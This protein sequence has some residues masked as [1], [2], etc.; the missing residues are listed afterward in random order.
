MLL[1]YTIFDNDDN[2]TANLIFYPK[3]ELLQVIDAIEL[4]FFNLYKTLLIILTNEI[5]GV[6]LCERLINKE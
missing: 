6:N 3:K 4:L 2:Q 1:I 5:V